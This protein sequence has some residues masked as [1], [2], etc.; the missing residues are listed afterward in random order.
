M[1]TQS[2]VFT[3]GLMHF[4]MIQHAFNLYENMN[5]YS[6]WRLKEVNILMFS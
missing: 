1:Q 3:E 2:Y 4:V 6:L 5:T